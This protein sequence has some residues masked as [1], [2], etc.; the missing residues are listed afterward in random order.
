MALIIS[1]YFHGKLLK[2]LV[3]VNGLIQIY[4]NLGKGTVYLL[5]LKVFQNLPT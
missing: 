2:L 5:G 1:L 3:S 4:A